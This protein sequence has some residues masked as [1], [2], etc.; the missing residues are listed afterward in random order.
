MTDRF[1]L[2][3]DA[4][5]V[6]Y[7]AA[8]DVAELLVPFV[9]ERG[10]LSDSTAIQTLYTQA[11]LGAL[12]ADEFWDAVG[13]PSSV[14]DDYLARHRLTVGVRDFLQ[15]L[16]RCVESVWCLSNDVSRWARK[17]RERNQL[18]DL[19][20]GSVISG[21]VGSR[22]PDAQIYLAL[23]HVL[24]RPASDCVFVDDRGKNLSAAAALGFRTIRF[25]GP[26]EG[27]RGDGPVIS[28]FA[29]LATYLERQDRLR[30]H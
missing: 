9:T 15:E 28:S 6:I 27:N 12:S 26:S 23:L 29:E 30:S 14:E 18:E 2:V 10:G 25:G 24:G 3:L 4:M 17:L 5:G 13:L 19:I 16:P 21:D 11:S 22:K 8:D 7:T 1:V 20:A